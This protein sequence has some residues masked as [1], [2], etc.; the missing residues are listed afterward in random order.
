MNLRR[1]MDVLGNK[2]RNG[3]EHEDVVRHLW[4]TLFLCVPVISTT[5][6]SFGR[7]FSQLWDN[8]IGWLLIDEA[9]QAS[10]KAAVGAIMRSQRAVVVGDPLQLEPII[11]LPGSIQNVL[12]KTFQA[13]PLAFS[14]HTSVQKRADYT[15]KYGTSLAS[16]SGEPIWVGSP[17]RVHRRCHS[18]MF[19][20]SNETTYKGLMVQGKG[21]DT[22][23]LGKSAWFDISSTTNNGHWIQEE[24][25]KAL[26][27]VTHLL[28]QD[29][30]KD[31]IYLIS[32]FK[33]VVKGLKE[34]FKK[35]GLIDETKRIGTIHTVQGKEAKV[36]I[37]V[38]GSDPNNN[39]A[40][41]WAASKP[42]L[43][44]VAVTRAKERL[45]I[46]GNKQKW[47][48]KR[49]FKKAVLLLDY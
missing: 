27:L 13:H 10:A 45:Y 41:Q 32:P 23:T 47:K 40:R 12:H 11:G 9:G 16:N 38:L 6:A 43:L 49:Y 33:D 42:N 46:I 25:K 36:V 7:L 17:L 4:A 26:E 24:G 5:F 35:K 8:K 14:E 37:F 48:D 21:E 18:P 2:I 39:G 20:I 44:N 31:D 1:L 22:C 28:Q 30:A 34:I 3:T 19:E 15:E 29:V